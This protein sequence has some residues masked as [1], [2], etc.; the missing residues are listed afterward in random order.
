[1]KNIFAHFTLIFIFFICL[2][3]SKESIEPLVTENENANEEQVGGNEEIEEEEEIDQIEISGTT[4]SLFNKDIFSVEN[5]STGFNLDLEQNAIWYHESQA[6]LIHQ[7]ITGNFTFTATVNARRKSNEMLAPDCNVCLGGLMARN[8]DNGNGEN[9]VHLV[10]GNI[11][12]TI[13]DAEDEI[14]VEYKSTTNGNSLFDAIPH[15]SADHELRMVRNGATF[16]LYSRAI[17]AAEWDLIMTYDRPDLPNTLQVGFNIYTAAAT[18]E[19]AADLKI[20]YENITLT[21]N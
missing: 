13:N 5:T 19:G 3:C 2:S 9:Y 6:G 14:G 18:N 10:A 21:N 1:M 11:P 15:N 20:L 16:S 17:N 7:T 4:W 8:P 12:E